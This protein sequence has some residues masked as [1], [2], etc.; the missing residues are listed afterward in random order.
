[1]LNEDGSMSDDYNMYVSYLES[2]VTKLRAESASIKDIQEAERRLNS[3]KGKNVQ[4]LVGGVT[5]SDREN[6]KAAVEDA[7]FNCKSAAKYGVGYGANFM[8]YSTIQDM[9]AKD[10]SNEYIKILCRAYTDLLYI[11]YDI[12][13]D[14][15]FTTLREGF[16]ENGCPMNI[17]THEYDHKV[18]SSI[19]S[20]VV[21]LET[22]QHILMNMFTCNQYLVQTPNHNIYIAEDR[23]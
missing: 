17:R 11:L 4:F 7:V 23:D 20:D 19:R 5:S 1:M 14:E 22:I 13:K 18:L 2:I 12:R 15:D 9:L 8:A 6:T 21:I 16:K 3:F 10:P